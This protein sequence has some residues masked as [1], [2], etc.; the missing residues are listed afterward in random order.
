MVIPNLV[1]FGEESVEA[2]CAPIPVGCPTV[3]VQLQ[4]LGGRTM[5]SGG[6]KGVDEDTM[7]NIIGLQ[8]EIVK[9]ETLMVYGGGPGL[10]LGEEICK[11]HSV[12]FV[13]VPNRAT[14]ATELDQERGF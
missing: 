8:L 1:E 13:G 9:P 5:K 14:A 3:S 11:R 10:T 7:R 4:T 6:A 12:R 2:C